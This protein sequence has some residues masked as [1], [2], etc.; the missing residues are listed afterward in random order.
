LVLLGILIFIAIGVSAY[1]NALK[2]GIIKIAGGEIIKRA[3]SPI[4]F[5]FT[6]FLQ[7]SISMFSLI[8]IEIVYLKISKP[9]WVLIVYG[10]FLIFYISILHGVYRS[11]KITKKTTLKRVYWIRKDAKEFKR[12]NLFKVVFALVGMVLIVISIL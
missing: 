5:L 4:N 11:L 9:H 3:K 12:V 10:V 8:I 7:L 6:F 1:F 2:K